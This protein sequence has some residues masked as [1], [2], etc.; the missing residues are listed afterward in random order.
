MNV[1][2]AWKYLG[3]KFV[4]RYDITALCLVSLGTV[5]IVYVTNKEQQQFTIEELVGL[6]VTLPSIAYVSATVLVACIGHAIIP[7]LL[8]RLRA[9]EQD[10]DEWEAQN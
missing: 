3:E 6:L 7:V 9:F 8:Q 4:P 5:V 10:C 2:V 1:W